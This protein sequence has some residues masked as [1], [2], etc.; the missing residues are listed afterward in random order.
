MTGGKETPEALRVVVFQEDETWIAQCLEHDICAFAP[1]RAAL[2]ERFISLLLFEYNL[3]I[4]RNGSPFAGID[5]APQK[6]HDMWKNHRD[7]VN[8]VVARSP[9][10]MA[11]AA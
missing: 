7:P 6:F 10:V 1:D 9:V 4:E 11:A 3:S 5:P 2:R 8:L